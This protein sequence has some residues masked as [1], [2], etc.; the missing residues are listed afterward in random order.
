MLTP[1]YDQTKDGLILVINTP[2]SKYKLNKPS[3]EHLKTPQEVFTWFRKA[4]LIANLSKCEFC[5]DKVTYLGYGRMT[6]VNTKIQTIVK[7]SAPT[8]VKRFLGMSGY[9]TTFC[10]NFSDI[11]IPLTNLRQKGRKFELSLN[12]QQVFNQI[13]VLL[14]SYLVFKSRLSLLSTPAT[15]TLAQSYCRWIEILSNILSAIFPENSMPMRK[16]TQP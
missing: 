14:C 15:T 13:K 10:Q 3:K 8:N 4:N 6:R 7:C 9:Y 12:C 11:S 16:I 1:Y 2:D 5:R